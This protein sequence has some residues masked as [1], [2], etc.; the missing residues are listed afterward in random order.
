MQGGKSKDQNDRLANWQY[1]A[2][3]PFTE[4]YLPGALS[5]P[6]CGCGLYQKQRDSVMLKKYE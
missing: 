4:D 1:G 3:K 5:G 6:A 2:D